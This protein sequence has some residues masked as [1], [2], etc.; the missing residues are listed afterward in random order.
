MAD[1]KNLVIKLK[2]PA[3]AKKNIRSPAAA[4]K[5][6]EWNIKR[7]VAAMLAVVLA[8]VFLLALLFQGKTAPVDN[9]PL[10]AAPSSPATEHLSALAEKGLPTQSE[11]T[12]PVVTEPPA[13]PKASVQV[14]SAEAVQKTSPAHVSR[15]LL[16]FKV[17]KRNPMTEIP[18]LVTVGKGR[19]VAIHYFTEVEG[20][21]GHDVFHEWLLNGKVIMRYTLNVEKGHW[22]TFSRMLLTGTSQGTWVVRLLDEN[23]QLLNQQTFAVESTP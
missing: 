10:P 6:T 8:V 18:R 20:M 14:A 15:A 12:L 17:K 11:A 5:A 13:Q 21:A 9:I 1:K 23:N 22:P 4:E 19:S 7:V 3:G 16:T 2:Y